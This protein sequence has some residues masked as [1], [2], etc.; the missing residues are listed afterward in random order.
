MS[1]EAIKLHTREIKPHK[2]TSSA[3][4]GSRTVL[5]NSPWEYVSL[6]LKRKD[7]QKALFYWS[8]ARAFSAGA[9]SLPPESAPLL[10]YYTFMN[11]TKALLVAKHVELQEFHGVRKHNMR[12]ASQSIDLDN[13]GIRIEKNGVLPGLSRILQ[14]KEET[15]LH[16]M[17][18]LLFNIPCIHRTFCIT[19]ENESEIFIPLTECKYI[20]DANSNDAYLT[21]KISSDFD[22]Q[23]YINRLPNTLIFDPAGDSDRCIRSASAFKLTDSTIRTTNDAAE[24]AKLNRQLRPDLQYIA[25]STTLWYAKAKVAQG[26][27]RLQRSPLTL[28]LAAMHR[29]SELSRYSPME[30]SNFFKGPQN[31]LLS[32]FIQMAP[33]QFIDE[34]SAE[35]TGHQCMTPNV[36][37]AS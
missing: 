23:A 1:R 24:I 14:E 28:I 17:K 36:R 21:G 22:H 8:Q 32:E 6:W 11:A 3:E 16:S 19:Y 10:H 13:E 20:F 26:T 31:W 27:N 12:N 34:I 18:E 30:L 37:P 4:F 2:A 29:L 25:G 35:I 15:S 7:A 5:T 9:Q 33:Q